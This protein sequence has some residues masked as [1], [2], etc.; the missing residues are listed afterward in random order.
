VTRSLDQVSLDRAVRSLCRREADFARVVNVFGS[1]PLWAREPGFATLLYII[2]EQQVSLASARAA[3]D[4]L[5][6]TIGPPTPG[7]FL[8]LSDRR[9]LRIRFSRQKR[10]YGQSLATEVLE[11]RL[12]LVELEG[13]PDE[14]AHE[15]LTA[16]LGVGPWTADIYL[17]MAL[18][19]PDI[20]PRG[21]VALATATWRLR[22]LEARPSQEELLVMSDEWTPW[23]SVAARILWHYYLSDPAARARPV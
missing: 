17:L 7:A 10:R 2:L 15:R 22:G 20:W 6:A 19:R 1:P 3:M 16:L 23:R 18:R 21:D 9:L 4:R 5:V 14:A 11:G 13:M 8:R 12:D